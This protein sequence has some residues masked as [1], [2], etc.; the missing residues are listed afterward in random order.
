MQ[1]EIKLNFE[2]SL[3]EGNY[4][5]SQKEIKEKNFNKFLEQGFPNK[6][7]EDWK[8]SDLNQ[9]ISTNF[10]KLDFYKENNTSSIN[11]DY[12]NEF[13]HNKIVFINGN[14]SKI[15]FGYEDKEKISINQNLELD[16][17]LNENV[18]INLNTAFLSSYIKIT[19]N[20]GYQ[21]QKPLVLYNYLTSDLDCYGLNM[22]LDIDLED[23]TSIDVINISNETTNNNFLNFRQKINIGKNA[24]LKNYSLDINPTSNIKYSF[25]DID[26]DK[27]SHLE[28][29]ILSKGSKFAKHDI[30]CSLNNDHGSVVLNGVIDLD[31]KKHH[32]IKTSINHNEENCKSY[33]LI[34][35]VLNENSK[36][37][38]QGKIYVD[39]KAQKTDGYQLSRALLLND[40][41]EFNAKPELEIYADDV[42]CSHGSTSGN[43]DENS[44]F[45]LM[46]RGLSHAQSK[47]LLTNGF[48]N[49][50]VEKITN[51]SVKSLVK[52]LTGIQE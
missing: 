11:N 18:L 2:K 48:L 47:K 50:V 32:E 28:Y 13:K 38:Y 1:N 16:N 36:G 8:F 34:K 45:Y 10:E 23:D 14:V 27:N 24:T 26:L 4:S 19:I 43:I 49:E 25:K 37:V 46:S 51:E 31:N 40:N 22:R 42:K 3:S 44:I 41:V 39:S 20:K 35:S 33:Q 12:I 52:K 9:I 30:N 29:F 17:E 6:R 21:L 7:I 5:I 15:D